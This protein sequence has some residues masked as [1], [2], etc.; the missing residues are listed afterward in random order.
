MPDQ[1]LG[2][3]V[4]ETARTS[5]TVA[6]PIPITVHHVHLDARVEQIPNGIE[7]A[8]TEMVKVADEGHLD[9]Y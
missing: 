5:L 8:A 3:K 9:G 6:D 1:V 7:E 2:L 4:R